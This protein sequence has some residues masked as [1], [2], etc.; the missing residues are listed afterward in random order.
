MD[1]ALDLHHNSNP[2]P[3]CSQG[4]G[5]RRGKASILGRQPGG[6]C[7]QSYRGKGASPRESGKWSLA[8]GQSRG[9]TG[10]WRG[11]PG[12]LSPAAGRAAQT[13]D[14][15]PLR[16]TAA[17]SWVIFLARASRGLAVT[18]SKRLILASWPGFKGLGF[19]RVRLCARAGFP[20]KCLPG[21]DFRPGPGSLHESGCGP[22][23]AGGRAP[24]GLYETLA[25]LGGDLAATSF[26]ISRTLPLA[27]A[28][29]AFHGAFGHGG[30]ISPGGVWSLST[31]HHE[32]GGWTFPRFTGTGP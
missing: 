3:F 9:A 31:W 17:V 8:R 13:D 28:L 2:S 21:S 25:C 19:G 23:A 20:A 10:I 12:F 5:T 27:Q 6:E 24:C 15:G 32:S 1:F 22:R 26:G 11:W 4:I 30:M 18:C 16:R 29:G 7:S 14:S